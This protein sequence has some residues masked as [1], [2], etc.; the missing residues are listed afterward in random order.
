MRRKK[1]P[2]LIEDRAEADIGE[3]G[4]DNGPEPEHGRGISG[5]RRRRLSRPA[6]KEATEF[7]SAGVRSS[8]QSLRPWRTHPSRC[9]MGVITHLIESR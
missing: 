4:H 6:S 5:I 1:E 7:A 3:L 9:R 8:T 2:D